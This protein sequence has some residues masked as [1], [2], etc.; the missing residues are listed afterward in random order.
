MP[1]L[2]KSGGHDLDYSEK[3]MIESDWSDNRSEYFYVVSQNPPS[4]ALT[5]PHPNSSEIISLAM[6]TQLHQMAAHMFLVDGSQ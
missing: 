6:P 1:S 3:L 5:A 2:K 4:G